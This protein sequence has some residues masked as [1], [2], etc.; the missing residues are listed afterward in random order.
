MYENPK[1]PKTGKESLLMPLK[2]ELYKIP[3]LIK[4]E[5]KAPTKKINDSS[6]SALNQYQMKI[7]NNPPSLNSTNNESSLFINGQNYINK[8]NSFS[9]CHNYFQIIPKLKSKSPLLNKITK[10][11]KLISLKRNK[12]VYNDEIKVEKEDLILAANKKNPTRLIES[13]IK[14]INPDKTLFEKKLK[15]Y[16]NK[17]INNIKWINLKPNKKEKR[18][19]YKTNIIQSNSVYSLNNNNSK[20]K[21]NEKNN[22]IMKIRNYRSKTEKINSNKYGIYTQ[23]NKNIS[24]TKMTES[25]FFES[26]LNTEE[27]KDTNIMNKSQY[28]GN[29]HTIKMNKKEYSD[30]SCDTNLD[31]LYNNNSM[32]NNKLNMINDT[33]IKFDYSY[34]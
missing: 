5:I 10:N 13:I 6:F 2:L 28:I 24:M 14:I 33:N 18:Q 21:F 8:I 11:N 32:N 16:S 20:E 19:V 9:Q 31:K 4:K 25:N 34:N 29:Y 7:N 23:K 17:N 1:R 30:A 12:K 22:T 26:K 3:K 27:Q 15:N